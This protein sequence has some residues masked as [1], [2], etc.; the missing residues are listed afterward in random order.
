MF[1]IDPVPPL[2]RDVWLPEIQ[3]MLARD[4]VGSSERLCLAAKG[5]HNAESHNYNDVG[6]F[7]VYIDGKPAIVDAGVET[8]TRK[9][10]SAERYTIWPMQSGYHSLL[11]TV[12]GL[13]QS[14]GRAFAAVMSAM[15]PTM[16]WPVL[17]STLLVP[18]HP[19][20]RVG[21]ARPLS[22]VARKSKLSIATRCPSPPPR[23]PPAC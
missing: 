16:A 1:A 20:L 14:P 6:N 15:S 17:S 22:T 7:I 4:Q 19:R 11:P 13:M 18:T 10:F 23:S 8:Y 21:S 5:G 9:T 12:D 3:V 2:P